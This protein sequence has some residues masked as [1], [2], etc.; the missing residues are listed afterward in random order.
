MQPPE[1]AA[2]QKDNSEMERTKKKIDMDYEKKFNEALERFKTFREKYCTYGDLH[3]GDVI[4][5]KTGEAQKVLDAI[6]PELAELRDNL[7]KL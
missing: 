2:G 6:F 4:F 1:G 7:K 3:F 5:D